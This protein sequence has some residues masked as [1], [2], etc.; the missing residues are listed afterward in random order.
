M[1]K[2]EANAVNANNRVDK[3]LN[4]IEPIGK[5]VSLGDQADIKAVA[6]KPLGPARSQGAR[7]S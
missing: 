7:L 4:I 2:A 6:I 1:V 3:L 5:A